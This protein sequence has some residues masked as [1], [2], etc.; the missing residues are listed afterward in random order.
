MLKELQA[1]AILRYG[2][3]VDAALIVER[4]KNDRRFSYV[5]EDETGG[6]SFTVPNDS[7]FVD[8]SPGVSNNTDFQWI[9]E[10]G[11]LTLQRAWDFNTGWAHVGMI[12]SGI[13]VASDPA[14][15]TGTGRLYKVDHPDLQRVVSYNH[16]WDFRYGS[17]TRRMIGNNFPTNAHG[18][19]TTGIVAANANNGIG[20][21]GICWNCS[22]LMGQVQPSAIDVPSALSWQAYWGAQVVNFSGFISPA[23]N[24]SASPSEP[25]CKALALALELDVPFV[26]AAGNN[27]AR[28]NF[29]ARD[30]RA[31]A[32]GGIDVN[33][34]WWDEQAWPIQAWD[35]GTGTYAGCPAITP[36][37]NECGANYNTTGSELDFVAPARDIISTVPAGASYYPALTNICNDSNYGTASDGYAYCTGTSMSAPMVTGV[38]ALLR[39]TNPLITRSAV[40]DVLKSTA[41]G[42]GGSYDNYLG[43]G[44]PGAR[45]AVMEVLGH[46]GGGPIESRLTPM[47]AL[48]ISGD[49]LYTT[50]PQV[51]VGA[52]AGLYLSNA[53]PNDV[54]CAPT[55][56]CDFDPPTYLN[57]RY[58]YTEPATG[59]GYST[60]N[61]YA[62]FPTYK[63][64]APSRPMSAFWVFTS[65]KSPWAGVQLKPLYRMSY[66]SACDNREHTYS[67]SMTEVGTLTS[68][69]DLCATETGTQLREFDG[70]EGYV[71]SSCPPSY[72]CDGSDPTAPQKLYRRR[73]TTLATNAL[74]VQNQLG[75]SAFSTY[76]SVPWAADDGFLGY[77][78]PNSDQDG[79]T[80]IDGMERLYGLD[81]TSTD[82][83]CDGLSDEA[84]FPL[85]TTQPV[86]YDPL[87]GGSCP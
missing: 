50:R 41:I 6:F 15:P 44:R 75:L 38:I 35:Y 56:A 48:S 14:P 16:S 27:R 42:S 81:W 85:T 53:F 24:C 57:T 37:G 43:W 40:Y 32:V 61:G 72:V 76:T 11:V 71:M 63:P 46:V 54:Y 20:V 19:H 66:K 87:Q 29:P 80:L 21:A 31:I 30:S 84:E 64:N 68:L 22:V 73:S 10:D 34:D 3:D 12:D 5:A 70:I 58:P 39:S 9:G 77:V 36:A 7:I 79:D 4:L 45:Y 65:D 60:V 18:T 2:P 8:P 78:F 17:T 23:V 47:F 51:A 28:V 82:S 49:R 55:V 26:A 62:N 83:D 67:V 52:L 86:S 59:E 33:R 13:A 69:P 1:Y 74:L 25:M